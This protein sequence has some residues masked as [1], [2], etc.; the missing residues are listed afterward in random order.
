MVK[1]AD[2][3]TTQNNIEKCIIKYVIKIL[4]MKIQFIALGKRLAASFKR[5]DHF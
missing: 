2:Q 1:N 3:E 4:V 5:G